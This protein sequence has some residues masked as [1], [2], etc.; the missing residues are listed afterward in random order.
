MGLEKIIDSGVDEID[1]KNGVWS[2]TVGFA[3]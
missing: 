1:F 2:A 3:F